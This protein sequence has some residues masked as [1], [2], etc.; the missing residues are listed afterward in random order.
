[1][2]LVMV[3]IVMLVMVALMLMVHGSSNREAS[4][5]GRG[6]ERAREEH[7]CEEVEQRS[8]GWMNHEVVHT[9]GG[10]QLLL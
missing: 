6:E 1:M 8:H 10:H 2:V 7:L 4:R 5:G 9:P 3:A